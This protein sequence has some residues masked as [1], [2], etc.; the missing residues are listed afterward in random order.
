MKNIF[1]VDEYS[2]SRY[3][4]IG[5][6]IREL[7]YCLKKIDTTIT[8]ISFNAENDKFSMVK[9]EGLIKILF[10][11]MTGFCFSHYKMITYFLK[12]YIKDSPDNLFLVN[13][14]P[15]ED[16]LKSIKRSFPLSKSAFVIHDMGWTFRFLGDTVKY[17][18]MISSKHVEEISETHKELIKYYEEEQRMYAIVDKVIVLAKETE[19]LLKDVYL[20]DEQKMFY[21]PNG[22]RDS[23]QL[24]EHNEIMRIKSELHITENEKIIL[25]AGRVN[26][27]KGSFQLIKCFEKVIQSYP[28]CRLVIIGTLFEPFNT[29][30]YSS[31]IAS[32]IT[33]TGQITS[34]RVKDWYRVAD[35]GILPSFVE[36]CS[37]TGIEMLMH[38]LPIV[39]SDGFC[40]KDMFHNDINAQIAKI[41][42]R[43]NLD[44]FEAN[45]AN[46]ILKLLNSPEL[47][48]SL[49]KRSR[50]IYEL[51]Y[52]AQS[53]QHSYQE[54]LLTI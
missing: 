47:C 49:S 14:S 5:T 7:I 43:E 15:C 16:F 52:S 2:S 28:N 27:I 20:L 1:I 33:Y 50:E 19:Q 39:A 17:K 32:K 11:K 10:P 45:L 8:L 35:I 22:L 53:M 46:M 34:D 41:E 3:N 51:N 38:G 25:Y 30:K 44:A 26:K 18:E 13:H 29:L 21:A 9:E 40:V 31:E 12:L 54:L 24:L 23:S 42:D 37:Y 6:Y 48:C 36:Q 4:G